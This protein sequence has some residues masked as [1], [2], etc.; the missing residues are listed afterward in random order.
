MRYG[1]LIDCGTLKYSYSNALVNDTFCHVTCH[2]L[3]H[4]RVT[5]W[6]NKETACVCDC[7]EW[8][9]YLLNCTQCKEPRKVLF[10][11]RL[12]ILAFHDFSQVMTWWQ[13]F[14]DST[15]QTSSY[16][17]FWV[18]G[19]IK[20]GTLSG[21]AAS[22]YWCWGLYNPDQLLQHHR[23]ATGSYSSHFRAKAF[24]PV[25]LWIIR[26]CLTETPIVTDFLHWIVTTL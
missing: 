11:R 26:P 22:C 21:T 18:L 8:P 5:T 14:Y 7:S 3:W 13:C 23:T 16:T 10:C 12:N 24:C 20:Q 9:V 4:S 1:G 19:E 25:G 15:P 2:M 17:H 6:Q